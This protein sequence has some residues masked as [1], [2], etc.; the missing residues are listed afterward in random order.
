MNEA[1]LL[2]FQV[3]K[4]DLLS[5]INNLDENFNPGPDSIPCSFIKN[6]SSFLQYPLLCLFNQ[7]LKSGVFPDVWKT[8]FVYPVFKSEDRSSVTNYRPISQLSVIP[9]LLDHI[10]ADILSS[11]FSSI[12]LEQQHGFVKGRSTVTN[13]LLFTDFIYKALANSSQVDAVYMDFSKA[14]DVVNLKRLKLKCLIWAL[15]RR[16]L[17]GSSHTLL[18]GCKL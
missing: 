7:S 1:V 9:K 10:I 6:C 11:K 3:N 13:L 18:I 4:E 17:T 12:I 2:E 5:Y 16:P 15:G 14:F 8:S